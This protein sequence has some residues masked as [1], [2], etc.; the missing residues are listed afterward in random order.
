[1]GEVVNSC[2]QR[3]ELQL[4]GAGLTP[5]SRDADGRKV[6]RSSIREFLCSEAMH[7]LGG[8]TT[9]AATCI[10]SDDKV[11]RDM[12]YR[13]EPKLETCSVISRMAPTFIRFGSFEIFKSLDQMTGRRGPSVGR[14]DILTKLIDYVIE[15]FFPEIQNQKTNVTEKYETFYEEVVIRT[16][17]LVAF[18]Q[19]VG[20]CHGVLNTDNMSIIGLTLDYGP[21]GFIDR[22]DWDHV[23]NTS[24]DGGRY[25][26][27][28]QPEIC[29]WNLLKLA[30]S[31]ELITP[32]ERLTQILENTYYKTFNTEFTEKML[33]KF[34]LFQSVSQ[35]NKNLLSDQKLIQSFLDTM[36]R[37]GADFTNCFRCLS[38]LSVNG[39]SD[40][41]ESKTRLVTALLS[42]CCSLRQMI[43]ANEAN[44]DSNQFRLFLALMQT[45][46]QLLEML[47]KGPKAIE[48]VIARIDKIKRLKVSPHITYQSIQTFFAGNHF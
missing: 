6:L 14:K 27:A 36:E 9:R 25:S 1:M 32:L 31:L 48:R 8:P 47:G 18:W 35:T 11:V 45:N 10:A 13:G 28:K 34:G 38:Q 2:G 37:T 39:L 7:H 3:W 42:Q 15:T 43:E 19:S 41:K 26:Y 12:F 20:F 30:E 4:K 23:P 21:F 5:Y 17:K 29:K 22:F 24:D 16:A 44:F 40:H 33:K 46:P